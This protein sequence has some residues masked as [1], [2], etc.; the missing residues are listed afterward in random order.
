MRSTRTG[1]ALWLSAFLTLS[2][3]AASLDQWRAEAARVRQLADNDTPRA[4]DQAQHLQATLPA[5]ATPADQALALNLVSRVETYL[6]LT[7]LAATH[8]RDA[9]E[10]AATSADRV[11]QA[12]S[13]LN[14]ALNSI[15]Q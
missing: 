1:T 13:D 8:A 7:D 10:L 12:E 6:G 5:T 14:V 11:G 2:A 4:Y 9:F 3:N 15:N